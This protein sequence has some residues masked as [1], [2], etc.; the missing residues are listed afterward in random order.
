MKKILETKFGGRNARLTLESLQE[1][2]EKINEATLHT[3]F[4]QAR[5]KP[6][7]A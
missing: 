4:A 2:G 3:I 7:T 6:E 1:F 5:I